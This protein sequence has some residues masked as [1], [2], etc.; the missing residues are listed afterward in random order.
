M[1]PIT[2]LQTASAIIGIVDFGS[3]LLSSTYEIYQ[4]A[5]GYTARDV[6]LSTLSEELN[7]LGEQLQDR[8]QEA[9]SSAATSDKTLQSLSVRCIE[10][11]HKLHSAIRDLQANRSEN[12][13]ISTAANSFASALKAV[14]KK[15]EIESLKEELT[16]IRSQITVA[17]IISVLSESEQDD[18]KHKEL[19]DR[20]DQIASELSQMTTPKKADHLSRRNQDLVHILWEMDW[21]SW[22]AIYGG[23]LFVDSQPARHTHVDGIIPMMI[24]TSLSFRQINSRKEAIPEAHTSTCSWIFR[25]SETDENGEQLEWPSFPTWLKQRDDKIYWITGKPGSGKST[26]MKYIINNPE[27]QTHLQ[28]YAGDLPCLQAGFFFWNPGAEMETSR[29]GLLR[30]LLHQCLKERPALIPVVAPRRWALYS[31]LGDEA[32]APE[33]TWKELSESFD[34]LCSFHGQEFRL[35][36]F[37]DGLDEF[38]E[39]EKSPDV[40]ISWIRHAATQYGIKICV[41]SRPWNIFADAFG[42]EPSLTMQNL[43]RRDIAH[44]VRTEFDKSIAFQ[45]MKEAF[46]DDA[47]S[48][49]EEIIEKA[50]GVFLWVSLVVRNLLLT[51]VDNPSLGDLNRMLAEIP[52]D[53]VG[54]YNA[55][56]RSIPA[57]RQCRSSQI[58]QV[59]Q[60]CGDSLRSCTAEIMWLATVHNLNPQPAASS[61]INSV[62]KRVLDGHT[63]GICELV[64]GEVRFLH[65]SAADWIQDDSTRAKI[66]SK[67]PPDFEPHLNF[68]EAHIQLQVV[69]RAGDDGIAFEPLSARL[70]QAMDYVHKQGYEIFFQGRSL[71]EREK[72]STPEGWSTRHWLLRESSNGSEV[73]NCFV[74]IVASAGFVD[75]VKKKLND[76]PS[77]LTPKEGRISILENAIFGSDLDPAP[78]FRHGFSPSKY[79]YQ[80]GRLEIIR[81]ILETSPHWYK[82]ARDRPIFEAVADS[83]SMDHGPEGAKWR[84]EVLELLEEFGYKSFKFWRGKR[85][86]GM[87]AGS[88]NKPTHKTGRLLREFKN[89]MG[90]YFGKV[91]REAGG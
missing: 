17:G 64:E 14:W 4:S 82:T 88:I 87:L 24:L 71:P 21:K 29:E 73:E 60:V 20:L 70:T 89:E 16:E 67:A 76:D 91:R 18:K 57:E 15:G 54:L 75:Y 44:F 19:K 41:S 43:S 10:A 42:R 65:R 1:D 22:A 12:S 79:S 27:L 58:L 66:C 13:R 5:S 36:L 80:T 84:Q 6:G 25:D 37:I 33:W 83:E 56:W 8:L 61:G 55:I 81:F 53:I 68:L 74:G 77:L 30:T 7:G 48:I 39:S 23:G 11:S 31:V 72:N 35:A 34:I 62:L 2:A 38:K 32:V 50:Q 85:Y 45:E 26:L 9:P 49:I 52:S 69:V 40:L 47:T 90:Q 46:Q 86:Q 59:L 63:R 3:R 78:L 28:E 51:L